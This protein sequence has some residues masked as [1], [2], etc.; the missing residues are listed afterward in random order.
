MCVGYYN[1][2]RVFFLNQACRYFVF[3]GL[4]VAFG[5]AH[6]NAVEVGYVVVVHQSEVKFQIFAH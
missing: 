5:A 4:L 1:E 2:N 3:A 6:F